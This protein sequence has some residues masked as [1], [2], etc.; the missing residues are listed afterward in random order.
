MTPSR[1]WRLAARVLH[2]VRHRLLPWV[3]L[4][5]GIGLAEPTTSGALVPV[6]PVLLAGQVL[7]V[8]LNLTP[9]D[10][11]AAGRRLHLVGAALLLEWTVLPALAVLVS[12]AIPS[13][14]LA[15]GVVIC[16]VAPAEITSG[17]MAAVAGGDAALATSITAGSLALATFLVPAW[18]GVALGG[19]SQFNPLSVVGELG[20]SVLV[21]LLAGV[22]LRARFPRL[23][24]YRHLFLDL[25]A[26]CLVLVVLA[27]M[28]PARPALLS[29]TLLP[30]IL[31][32]GAVLLAGGA[33]GWGLGQALSLPRPTAT[34]VGFPVAIR[35]F[36]VA[37]AVAVAVLPQAAAVAGV[38]GILM[39]AGAG[40]VAAWLGSSALSGS[41]ETR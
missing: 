27:G 37:I 18:L 10:F 23:A 19:T 40:T 25:S 15:S 38:Y 39:V 33:L 26:A 14:E 30:I 7:G 5:V 24:R 6:V 3:V 9:A 41:R 8:S 32:A 11:R 29:A 4:A 34:A 13:R 35:E 28:G 2:P 36:G 16:A 21:P 22:V 1:R 17:L 31:L 20:L 12:R